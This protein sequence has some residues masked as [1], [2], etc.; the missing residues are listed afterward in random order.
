MENTW[1]TQNI[2]FIL[3][4]FLRCLQLSKEDLALA[5]KTEGVQ[6]TLTAVNISSGIVPVKLLYYGIVYPEKDVW[7]HTCLGLCTAA[8]CM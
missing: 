7:Y 6:D 2:N 3:C 4:S 8:M 5:S 1:E